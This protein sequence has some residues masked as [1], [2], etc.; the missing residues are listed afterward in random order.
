MNEVNTLGE[1]VR[2][3]SQANFGGY[4]ASLEV[5]IKQE[6]SNGGWLIIDVKPFGLRSQE[7]VEDYVGWQMFG[8]FWFDAD[9]RVMQVL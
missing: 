2:A 6:H 4:E 3:I 1:L 9:D 8:Q 7:I 5:E